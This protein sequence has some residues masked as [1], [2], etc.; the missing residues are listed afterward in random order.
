MNL[1]K[2]A[3]FKMVSVAQLADALLPDRVEVPSS[4]LGSNLILL[5]SV[6]LYYLT[7]FQCCYYAKITCKIVTLFFYC[8]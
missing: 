4:S 3:A 2:M 6:F 5:F 1:I 8:F 7:L